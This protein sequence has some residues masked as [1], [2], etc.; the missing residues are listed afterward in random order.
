MMKQPQI[1][2]LS[3]LVAYVPMGCDRAISSACSWGEP[4]SPG[5][6]CHEASQSCVDEEVVIAC[7]DLEQYDPCSFDGSGPNNVCIDGFCV[8]TLCGNGVLDTGETC[9]DG[10]LNSRDGCSAECQV[11]RCDC[12]GVCDTDL[13]EDSANCPSDCGRTCEL[14]ITDGQSSMAKARAF[15]AVTALPDGWALV[16]GGVVASAGEV[17]YVSEGTGLM[18][19]DEIELFNAC[20]GRFIRPTVTGEV[21]IGRAFHSAFLI[22]GSTSSTAHVLL[23]GGVGQGTVLSSEGV[24]RIRIGPQHPLR[25]TPALAAGAAAPM[26]LTIDLTQDP[27]V[28]TRSSEGLVG[29]PESYFQAGGVYDSTGVIV[30]G[31]AVSVSDMGDFLLTNDIDLGYVDSAEHYPLSGAMAIPRIGHTVTMVGDGSAGLVWGGNV[32]QPS[33]S[34]SVAEWLTVLPAPPSTTLM[35]MDVAG[36]SVDTIL[37]TAFHT[38]TP[39]PDGDVLVVGGFVVEAN[40]ALNP[41]DV[42]PLIRVRRVGD[43]YQVFPQ[44]SVAFTPVGYHAAVGLPDGRVLITGGSPLFEPGST[45][46]PGGENAWTC[47]VDQALVYTPGTAPEDGGS[48]EALGAG[49]LVVPRFGHTMTLVNSQTVLVVGGLWR[50]EVGLLTEST[51]E[52]INIAATCL[53]SE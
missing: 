39:L 14:V 33:P 22:E 26:L 42:A 28:V 9:D 10:N 45:P 35:T 4:C 13:G 7:L 16:T 11:E 48:L 23:V 29:W 43:Q 51:A 32:G 19:T 50:N 37:P 18:L 21:G 53:D 27:P 38:A 1:V 20:T 17:T 30:A 3:L 49:D 47:A 2:F 24:V 41:S 5:Q 34:Q 31:G 46:C 36:S 6:V 40:L 44:T 52:I 12:D 25:L 15:H 8:G